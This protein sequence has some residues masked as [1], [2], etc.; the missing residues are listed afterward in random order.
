MFFLFEVS[1]FHEWNLLWVEYH[2]DSYESMNVLSFNFQEVK[3]KHQWSENI[4]EMKTSMK[5]EHQWSGNINEVR[6]EMKNEMK[7]EF[8]TWIVYVV[9]VNDTFV[10]I[11]TLKFSFVKDFFFF[12]LFLFFSSCHHQYIFCCWRLL[13]S[14]FLLL[15]SSLNV[16][17]RFIF[18]FVFCLRALDS[19]FIFFRFSSL[20]VRFCFRWFCSVFFSLFTLCLEIQFVKFFIFSLCLR[21]VLT[22]SRSRCHKIRLW[23]SKISC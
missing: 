6:N 7:N 10:W 15:F 9:V 21:F 14:S 1:C 2:T 16:R 13:F 5:W 23:S 20:S 22:L 12:Q 11:F 18:V 19:F 3:W 4:N 8:V 17:I